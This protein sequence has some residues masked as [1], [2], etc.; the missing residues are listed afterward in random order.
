MEER[1]RREIVSGDH[2][3]YRNSFAVRQRMSTDALRT[4]AMALEESAAFKVCDNLKWELVEHGTHNWH[5][6]AP[7]A[8]RK[9]LDASLAEATAFLNAPQAADG[10][11]A[12]DIHR[13]R[14]LVAGYAQMLEFA[15][16]GVH[17]DVRAAWDN[18]FIWGGRRVNLRRF[19]Q[20]Y[21]F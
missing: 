20:V 3:A 18:A 10:L 14:R 6:D 2:I 19:K 16:Q 9:L 21:G 13:H 1:K 11:N 15:E 12:V 5:R 7:P 8:Y 17:V 4:Q